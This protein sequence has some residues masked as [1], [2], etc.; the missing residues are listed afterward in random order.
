[1]SSQ[2]DD[3]MGAAYTTMFADVHAPAFFQKLAADHNFV[4]ANDEQ[5]EQLLSM[6]EKLYDAQQRSQTKAAAA[7]TD[8]FAVANS[9]LDTL[10]GNPAPA[11]YAAKQAAATLAQSGA[12]KQAALTFQNGL[13]A[14]AAEAT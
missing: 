6:G 7:N 11:D 2:T 3:A 8:F 1:M 5:A 4:P 9:Q 13:L 14:Q 10:L 12:I